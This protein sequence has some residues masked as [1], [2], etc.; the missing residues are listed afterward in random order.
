MKAKSRLREWTSPDG[1]IRLVNA[2]CRD[3]LP[4]LAPGSVDAVVT[5]PPYGIK[6][7]NKRHD[8][9]PRAFAPALPGDDDG[10]IGQDVIDSAF[11]N[12]WP[13]CAFA[14]HRRPWH[15]EWRQWLVWDKGGAV[16]GG[17]DRS[18]CF[19][20]TWE[21][22]QLGGFGKLNGKR[23]EAVLRFPIGQ[24][25]LH[26]HPTQKPLPLVSYLLNK[27]TSE[28]ATVFDPFCGS[29]T[30]AVACIRTG[31]RCIGIECDRNYWQIAVARCK[32]EL[33]G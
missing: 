18:T 14:H 16:G 26:H 30:A 27:L 32:A 3:V 9:V 13:V 20:F 29:G 7:A 1:R 12:G 21:L 17:G 22:I 11:S 10:R 6:Y 28:S 23:D 33:Q 2:D 5:D 25:S 8:I 19:K 31:R 24:A 4:T 15:G